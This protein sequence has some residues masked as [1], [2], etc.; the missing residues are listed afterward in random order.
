VVHSLNNLLTFPFI[1][2]GVVTGVLA[3]HGAWYDFGTG[4]LLIYNPDTDSFEKA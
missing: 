4:T 3:L 2:E 1:A